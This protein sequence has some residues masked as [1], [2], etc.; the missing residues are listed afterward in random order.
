MKCVHASDILHEDLK[1]ENIFVSKD[2]TSGF[3]ARI[4]DFGSAQFVN[5]ARHPRPISETPAYTPADD[6]RIQA[7][8]V[9]SFGEILTSLGWGA[10]N[11]L[12]PIFGHCRGAAGERPTLK[13]SGTISIARL[14]T[15]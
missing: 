14:S 4:E 10:Y 2:P 3:H 8:D 7:F 12:N 6:P 11:D 13:I 15:A 1:P 9:F 5:A